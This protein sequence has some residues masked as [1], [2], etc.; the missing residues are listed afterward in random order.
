MRSIFFMN[1]DPCFQ[2]SCLSTEND[3]NTL[4]G[5]QEPFIASLSQTTQMNDL[6]TNASDIWPVCNSQSLTFSIP[7]RSWPS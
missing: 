4:Q 6:Q 1:K 5:E 7:Y 3:V 2:R